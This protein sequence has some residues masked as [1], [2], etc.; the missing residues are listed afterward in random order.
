MLL[1]NYAVTFILPLHVRKVRGIIGG[2]GN[3]F[4]RKDEFNLDIDGIQKQLCPRFLFHL[5]LRIVLLGSPEI[6]IT[7][8]TLSGL[9]VCML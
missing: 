8:D 4:S 1:E 5:A 6:K 3:P 7:T 2:G 9:L